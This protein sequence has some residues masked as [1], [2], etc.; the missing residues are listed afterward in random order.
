MADA[1]KKTVGKITRAPATGGKGVA[2]TAKQALQASELA[3]G[4]SPVAKPVGKAVAA[5]KPGFKKPVAAPAI[6][7]KVAAKPVVA[8][9]P[10]VTAPLEPAPV[11]RA[12]APVEPVSPATNSV[13]D[14]EV[15][16][17]T[18]PL[19][20][21]AP[22]KD[23]PSLTAAAE[24]TN[25]MNDVIE[26]SRKY[27]EEAKTRFQSAFA[28]INE[29]AKTGVEKSTKAIEEIAEIAKGNVEALVESGKIA[30]KGVE[31]LGQDAAEYG[32][33]SF[34]KASATMKSLA[35]V[36]SPT[37]FFQLQSE[38]LSGAFDAFAKESAKTS[39]ALIKLAGEV[40]QPISSRVSVVTD[41]V[42]SLAA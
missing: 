6:V 21:P 34:E 24:G 5:P 13:L 2:L 10:A 28:D 42:K 4:A 25:T 23:E 16:Q 33:L 37:E 17:H 15:A 1:P 9:A 26:N 14:G 7:E 40:A 30:A 41:K 19:N 39:E 11:A 36:K 18:P 35:A 38:L 20:I 12:E 8:K 32:R 22:E 31:T 3:T 27:T 29:K